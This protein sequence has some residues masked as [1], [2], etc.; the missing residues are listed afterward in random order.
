MTSVVNY[1]IHVKDHINKS[2]MVVNKTT[3]L[4]T[5]TQDFNM[6]INYLNKDDVY[7]VIVN[8][9]KDKLSNVELFKSEIK[10]VSGYIYNSTKTV[11]SLSYTLSL[12][13]INDQLSTIFQTNYTN[14]ETQTD[15]DINTQNLQTQEDKEQETNTTSSQTSE[16]ENDDDVEKYEIEFGEFQDYT[17]PA[18]SDLNTSYNSY[19]SYTP[20]T[21]QYQYDSYNS[22]N[23]Y[24]SYDSYI[25]NPLDFK[26]G[27][28]VPPNPTSPILS[29]MSSPMSSPMWGPNLINELKFR[30]TQP[31]SGLS[32]NNTNSIF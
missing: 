21:N 17:R 11:S 32:S 25:S 27:S 28:K 7:T 12:V 20:Y 18:F 16:Q 29:S 26:F 13:E 19:N 14:S 8:N 10:V 24:N 9:S 3:T 2:S 5:H 15:N 30:L 6:I 23:S 1:F 4:H 31:N 22:Y